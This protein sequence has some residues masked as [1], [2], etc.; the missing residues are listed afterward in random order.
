MTRFSGST[1][2]D[3]AALRAHD[4][5]ALLP[6]WTSKTVL[7]GAVGYRLAAAAA[8]SLLLWAAVGWALR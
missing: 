7:S 1:P 8:A 2:G 3:S 6:R 5:P 4:H